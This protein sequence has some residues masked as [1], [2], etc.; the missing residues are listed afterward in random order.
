L[1]LG[2]APRFAVDEKV[3]RYLCILRH[4]EVLCV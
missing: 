3:I 1:R 4:G 2:N